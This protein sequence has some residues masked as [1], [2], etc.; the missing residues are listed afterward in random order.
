LRARAVT[1]EGDAHPFT[2]KKKINSTTDAS[3]FEVSNR[4]IKGEFGFG[5]EGVQHLEPS[6]IEMVQD[7]IEKLTEKMMN[8]IIDCCQL[9]EKES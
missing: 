3:K 2:F 7:Q 1:W 4:S 9:Q 8:H 5:P 6:D